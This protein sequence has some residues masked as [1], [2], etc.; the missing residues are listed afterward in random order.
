MYFPYLE[1][2]IYIKID[3][4][5]FKYGNKYNIYCNHSSDILLDY[6]RT[7]FFENFKKIIQY[8]RKSQQLVMMYSE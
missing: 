3:K 8:P 7:L 5:I 4:V 6:K 2:D 1:L